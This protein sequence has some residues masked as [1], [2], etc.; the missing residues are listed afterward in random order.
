M[1]DAAITDIL[2]VTEIA[3]KFLSTL[4]W[5]FV[6]L[7]YFLQNARK[8]TA[9]EKEFDLAKQITQDRF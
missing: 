8:D 5:M 7:S 9:K 2:Y 4:L 3:E 1:E 6:F